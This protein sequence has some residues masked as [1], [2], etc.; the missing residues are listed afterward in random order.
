MSTQLATIEHG[1]IQHEPVELTVE[2]IIAKVAKVR[3][4]ASS[5]MKDG[6][7]FGTILGTPKPTLYKAGA[8]ILSL[9]FRL[10]PRYSGENEPKDLG[11]GHREFIIRCD[12][13]HIHTGVFYGSGLGSCSTMESKYRYRPGPKE[14]TGQPVPGDYWNKRKTDPAAAL[15]SIGGKGFAV[16]KDENG[17]WAIMLQGETIENPNIADTYNTV[18]KIAAKRSYLDAILK[19]TAASEVYT[20]D[21]EDMQENAT[22]MHEAKPSVQQPQRKSET[23]PQ[24]P[25]GPG[26]QC[27]TCQGETKLKPA[28][29]KK[30]GKTPYGAFWSCA[31]YPT[32][33]GSVQDS[34][35]RKSQETAPTYADHEPEPNLDAIPPD[36]PGS[37]G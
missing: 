10:A 14:S 1:M 36:E 17:A 18:L 26:P 27:P 28:G 6:I 33:K 23:Q 19:A 13:Y 20:Q 29:V 2:E 11:G 32:C 15:E 7:H 21:L 22:V 34:T 31:K 25:S 35:W 8:E 37:G 16:G 3:Q 4:V 12:L 30:D 9:T 24:T 5:V